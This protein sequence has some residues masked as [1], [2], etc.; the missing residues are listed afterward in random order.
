MKIEKFEDIKSWKM[1][2][3][4]TNTV[5]DLSDEGEFSK[6]FALKNQI[7]K[8]CLSVLSNIAEGFERDG[9]REFS[10]FLAIAKGSCGEAR[11][12]L[13]VALDRGYVTENEFKK[14]QSQLTQTGR[15]L[16]AFMSYL[17]KSELKGPKYK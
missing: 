16:S 7:R 9:N 12:Q 2:R 14:V 1:A 10:N 3:E 15:L 6:D 5:Y 8:S 17:K 4:V 11:A 13:Y